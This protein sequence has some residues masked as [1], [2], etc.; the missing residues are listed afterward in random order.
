MSF[1]ARLVQQTQTARMVLLSAPIIQGCLQGAVSLPSYVAFLTEA[2]HHVSHTVPLLRACKAALP[3]H[4]AWLHGAMDEYIDE[5]TGHDEWILNDIRACGAD[6]DAVRHGQPGHAAEVMVAYAYDTIARRNPL[7]FFGMVHVL[8][9]TSVSLALLAADSIQK[10][11]Q[12]PDAA[13]SYLR[14]H[15]T[16]DQEHTAHFELLMEQITDPKDQADIVHAAQ[17]FFRLYGDVFRGLPLPQAPHPHPQR[18][19]AGALA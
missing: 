5:E 3:A 18:D 19:T 17:A 9:G 4:H 6:A 15:G 13:F 1:H 11:L 14:S 16:L 12:L 2:Y 8:E 10:P 7:G